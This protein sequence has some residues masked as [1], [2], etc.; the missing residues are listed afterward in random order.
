MT[1]YVKVGVRTA[2]HFIIIHLFKEIELSNIKSGDQ[3]IKS[4]QRCNKTNCQS[5]NP[6]EIVNDTNSQIM[7]SSME[8]Q[9]E[10]FSVEDECPLVEDIISRSKIPKLYFVPNIYLVI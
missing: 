4:D 5:I 2:E 10:I 8:N 6:T 1:W 9:N 3:S 7:I